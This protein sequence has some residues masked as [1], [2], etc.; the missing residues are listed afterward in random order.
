M[1]A[2]KPHSPPAEK[3]RRASLVQLDV[4]PSHGKGRRFYRTRSARSSP[5]Q[6]RTRFFAH[7]LMPARMHISPYRSYMGKLAIQPGYSQGNGGHSQTTS[8]HEGGGTAT[9]PPPLLWSVRWNHVLRSSD[10]TGPFNC[11]ESAGAFP[12]RSHPAHHREPNGEPARLL[13]LPDL[14]FANGG[15]KGC[16]LV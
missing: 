12:P 1:T 5:V 3:S 11:F 10:G 4:A 7:M 8:T 6:N 13:R 2:R 9:M 14:G 16:Y 15:P